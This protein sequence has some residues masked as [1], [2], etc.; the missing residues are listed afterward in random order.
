[1]RPLALA[2]VLVLAACPGSGGDGQAL[3]SMIEVKLEMRAAIDEL[4]QASVALAE[5]RSE[6]ER[7]RGDLD[8]SRQAL[9]KA[10]ERAATRPRPD[11]DPLDMLP[12]PSSALDP[13]LAAGVT[14]VE[15]SVCTIKRSVFDALTDDP[16]SLPMQARIVP[17]TKDGQSQGFRLSGIRPGSLPKLIGMKNGDLITAV[18]GKSIRR[19]EDVMALSPTLRK[20]SK[21]DIVGERNGDP[22]TITLTIEDD[23]PPKR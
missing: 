10:L 3:E 18:N 21:L 12:T 15:E 20:A 13:T 8:R 2:A 6:I 5:A 11:L 7:A 16:S 4:K 23:T 14:C 22:L 19:I 17:S 9:D 1:M